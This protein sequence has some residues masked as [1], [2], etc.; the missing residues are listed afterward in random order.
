MMTIPGD[1]EQSGSRAR[2]WSR[3]NV[4]TRQLAP[5]WLMGMANATFGFY[6]GFVGISLP[7]LLAREH[8][9][10]ERIASVTA[11]VFS[12]F[13]WI[14]LVSPILDVRFTR[15]MYST[16][17]AVIAGISLTVGLL[18][19]KRLG[20]LEAALMLGSAASFLSSCALGGWLSSLLPKE[21][22]TRL[23][24]WFTV[25][26]MGGAG[27]MAV[28]AGELM[29][30]LP[31]ST[32]AVLL[33]LLIMVPTLIFL[34]IP[35]VLP[36][37]RLARESFAKFFGE[38]V[39]LVKQRDV[40]VA[41]AIFLAPSGSFALTNVLGGLGDEYHASPRIVSLIGGAGVSLA[42][43]FGS[44][45]YAPFAR[46]IPLRPLYLA[47]GIVGS[48]F[49]LTMLSR[50]Q[51]ATTFAIA[52]MGEGI[53]Q[54][55]AIAGAYAIQFEAIGRN[56]PLAATTFCVLNS[57]TNFSITYMMA[58]DGKA[59]GTHGLK[60]MYVADGGAG[61]LACLGL[62]ILLVAISRARPRR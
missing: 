40:L 16:L 37:R 27:A 5:I 29:R 61:I 53:F 45:L 25:S 28:I 36:D 33:G 17:F 43:V 2:E 11:L 48:L 3:W 24:S 44:L 42:G 47:I 7:Q 51:T 34:A 35:A 12:P 8:L 4:H 39:A 26:S 1:P 23:S 9:P 19:E 60:G 62:A 21:E 30:G 50:P 56:N 31:P 59:F 13:F 41:L 14:F 20:I 32:A 6:T 55:L 18:N 57:A 15:R 49:T 22:G 58:V 52:L 38:I 10:G 54:S 46:R